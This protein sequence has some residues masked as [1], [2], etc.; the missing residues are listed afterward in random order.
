MNIYPPKRLK[1]E[2]NC[3][4]KVINCLN[5]NENVDSHCCDKNEL[6]KI[7][8]NRNLHYDDDIYNYNEEE[9]NQNGR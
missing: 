8:T 7:D 9:L 5:T 4:P 6:N 2:N 3:V 1:V